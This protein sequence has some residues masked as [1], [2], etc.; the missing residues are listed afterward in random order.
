MY[1]HENS[2]SCTRSG[3][4]FSDVICAD[5]FSKIIIIIESAKNAQGEWKTAARLKSRPFPREPSLTAR[6]GIAARAPAHRALSLTAVE[7]LVRDHPLFWNRFLHISMLMN[8]WLRLVSWCSEQSSSPHP[9]TVTPSHRSNLP[10]THSFSLLPSP[11]YLD[12]L[13][14]LRSPPPPIYCWY[15][16]CWFVSESKSNL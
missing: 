14:D 4:R 7:P 9:D 16:C 8:P 6:I 13:E 1:L 15:L 5:S 2:E 3:N 11:S 10:L 12:S